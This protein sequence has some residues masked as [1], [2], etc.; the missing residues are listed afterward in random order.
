MQQPTCRRETVEHSV[1]YI[2]WSLLTR[3]KKCFIAVV[4]SIDSYTARTI[5]ALIEPTAHAAIFYSRYHGTHRPQRVHL[6]QIN[7]HYKHYLLDTWAAAKGT[8]NLNY[9]E[10]ELRSAEE[11]EIE[12]WTTPSPQHCPIARSVT[13]KILW[14]LRARPQAIEKLENTPCRQIIETI[15]AW[16]H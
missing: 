6:I 8:S 13:S 4:Y 5:E 2:L 7:N 11:L 14:A 1:G 3:V 16:P 15:T 10:L 12:T 9:Y